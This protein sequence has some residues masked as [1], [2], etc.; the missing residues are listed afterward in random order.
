MALALAFATLACACSP[1]FNWREFRAAEAPYTVLFPA[2]PVTHSRTVALDG[3]EA[4]MTMT[5]AEVDGTV[6]AVG[7]ATLADAGQSEQAARSM[8]AAMVRN[9]S[10]SIAKEIAR[11]NGVDIEAHGTSNGR[12]MQLHGRFLARDKRAYQVVVIGPDN[13]VDA[14][15]IDMFIRSF[16]LN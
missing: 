7:S 6:F 15:T 12:P 9:I 8:R 3:R 13:A 1:K 4:P 5:A 10:G 16:K 11:E 14:E 2:K